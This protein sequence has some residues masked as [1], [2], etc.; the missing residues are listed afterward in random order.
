LS[1]VIIEDVIAKSA[2]H[3]LEGRRKKGCELYPNYLQKTQNVSRCPAEQFGDKSAGTVLCLRS[4][5]YLV[6][7]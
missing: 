4:C 1:E 7:Y 2:Y 6:V 3:F 5:D